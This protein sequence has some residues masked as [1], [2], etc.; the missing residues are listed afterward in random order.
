MIKV[1]IAKGPETGRF[2]ALTEKTALIGRGSANNIRINEKSVSRTHVK[3]LKENEKY[4]IE[5]LRSKNGTW[6][7]GNVIDAG[8][9]VE[10]QQGVPVALGNVLISLGRK[11]SLNQLPRQYSINIVPSKKQTSELPPFVEHRKRQRGDLELMYNVCTALVKTLDVRELCEM[12]LE[13][14]FSCLKRIDEGIWSW[15]SPVLGS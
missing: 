15:P 9:R 13:C 1:Y 4:F 14:I 3:V 7:N 5:D 12:V 10:V 2:F 6:V 11:C 8:R